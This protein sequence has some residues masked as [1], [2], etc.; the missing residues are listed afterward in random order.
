MSSWAVA[1]PL[2][3]NRFTK[4]SIALVY[5]RSKK[6][7]SS[8]C[9]RP[10]H[11]Q[12]IF[13]SSTPSRKCIA[14]LLGG[15]NR[16]N[17]QA[18]I[19]SL[20]FTISAIALVYWRSKMVCSSGYVRR[21]HLEQIFGSSSPSRKCIG[22][23]LGGVHC[24]NSLAAASPLIFTIAAIAVVYWR[25][26]K[27]YSSGCVRRMHLEQIF[28]SSSPSRKCSC[29]MLGDIHCSNSP[30]AASPLISLDLL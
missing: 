24:S 17:S 3:F 19:S 13:G 20:I 16:S 12:Q 21:T 4:A 28:G 25:N 6:V 23:K 22:T 8:G 9:V 26:K 14:A 11:L 29:T 30:P 18:A 2:I 5:W 1:S 10:T 27:V 7:C 15:V